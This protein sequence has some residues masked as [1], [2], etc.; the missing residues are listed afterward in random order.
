T[1]RPLLNLSGWP[2][3]SR[4]RVMVTQSASSIAYT[5]ILDLTGTAGTGDFKG[6]RGA[7]FF[8][9]HL[10]IVDIHIVLNQVVPLG[11]IGLS[12]HFLSWHIRDAFVAHTRQ[13]GHR[14]DLVLVF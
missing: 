6:V 5:C 14:P 1:L 2:L 10:S 8:L 3:S 7:V 13:E 11:L 9:N 4:L 12:D